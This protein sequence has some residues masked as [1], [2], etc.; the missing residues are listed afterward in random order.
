LLLA[1]VPVVAHHAFAAEFDAKQAMEL[2]GTITK[3][4]WVNPHAWMHLAV[5]NKEG[6]TDEWMV[7]LGPPNGLFRRGWKK[8]S[9]PIGTEVVVFGYRAKDGSKKF[10]GRD[11]NFPDGRKLFV[12]STGTG[13]PDFEKK[14][15]EKQEK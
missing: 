9:V 13:A 6:K 12:G 3:M 8:D 4:D 2:K 15:G 10:N 1:S 7:E 11:A 14:P 5:K